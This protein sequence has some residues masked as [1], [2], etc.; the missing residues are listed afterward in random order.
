M[1]YS[2]SKTEKLVIVGFIVVLLAFPLVMLLTLQRTSETEMHKQTEE[3]SS[4]ITR[5]R[6]YYASEVVGRI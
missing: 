6:Q 2:N 4:A 1:K 3:I 5:L